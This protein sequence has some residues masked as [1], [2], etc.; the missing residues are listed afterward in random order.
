MTH[1]IQTCGSPRTGSSTTPAERP[2]IGGDAGEHMAEA[3]VSEVLLTPELLQLIFIH[4]LDLHVHHL[5]A[6]V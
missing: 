1:H 3:V 4:A 6:H 2:E 5:A